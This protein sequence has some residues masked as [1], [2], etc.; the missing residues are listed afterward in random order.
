MRQ[1]TAEKNNSLPQQ[2]DSKREHPG[3]MLL[4]T[5]GVVALSAVALSL[6]LRRPYPLPSGTPAQYEVRKDDPDIVVGLVPEQNIFSQRKRYRAL[7]DHVGR[8]IGVRI[9]IRS[10]P[11]YGAVIRA[12][13][14]QTIDAAFL[15]SLAYT[16]AHKRTGVIVLARPVWK[17]GSSTYCSYIFARAD[18]GFEEGAG[19]KAVESMRGKRLALV[20][21]SSMAGYLFPVAFFRSHGAADVD[22][23]FSKV[24]MSGSHD[25]AALA[26]LDNQADVGAA[27]SHPVEKLFRRHPEYRRKIVILARSPE[28]P[29][30]GLA[31]HPQVPG[32]V[33][34]QLKSGLLTLMQT[35][36]GRSVLDAFGARQFIATSDSD[37]ATLYDMIREAGVDLLTFD[38]ENEP[39]RG[40]R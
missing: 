20:D 31:V 24:H 7:L 28:A 9:G 11:T 8:R 1:S 33:R 2:P 18:S 36:E 35:A 13:E 40:E 32:K 15:G 22:S 5:L 16:L 27:K 38:T 25:A 4:L 3:A 34:E 29:S 23:Y 12:L 21:R 6:L 14:E 19:V 30:D 10:L 37:Y 17:D 26:V 39:R